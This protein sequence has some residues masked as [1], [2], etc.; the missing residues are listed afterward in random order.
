M[1]RVHK[2]YV[3]LTGKVIFPVSFK[4]NFINHSM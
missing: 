3:K 2:L 1:Q 4:D